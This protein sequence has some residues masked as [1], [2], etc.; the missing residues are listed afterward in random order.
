VTE[1]WA[2]NIRWDDEA[3]IHQFLRETAVLVAKR[4]LTPAQGQVMARL[5]EERLKG[6][7]KAPAQVPIYVTT[8]FSPKQPAETTEP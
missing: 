8:D 5:A 4:A 3:S 7:E 2:D 1:S 6:F